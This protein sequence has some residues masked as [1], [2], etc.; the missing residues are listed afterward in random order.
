MPKNP[1]PSCLTTINEV[2]PLF[3]DIGL[4]GLFQRLDVLGFKKTLKIAPQ[5]SDTVRQA[6][7]ALLLDRYTGCIDIHGFHF[8]TVRG[9]ARRPARFGNT[10][11]PDPLRTH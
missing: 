10:V 8:N 6:I 7:M 4:S 11:F 1:E 5:A 9:P 3:M 2:N